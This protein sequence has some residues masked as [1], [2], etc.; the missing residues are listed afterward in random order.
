MIRKQ[1]VILIEDE[2][3]ARDE[4]K[5]ILR[6]KHGDIDAETPGEGW[7]LIRQGGVDGVFLDINL[8]TGSRREGMDL[9]CEI[10]NLDEPPW[11]VFT[12]AYREYGAEAFAVDPADFLLKPLDDAKVARALARV[13]PPPPGLVE[14]ASLPRTIEIKHRLA[15]AYGE[16]FWAV[17]YV[18]PQAE[19]LY[20]C[21]S[22]DSDDT[23]RVHLLG[24]EDLHGVAGPLK[25][26]QARLAPYGFV[27]IRR[28]H[29]VNRAFRGRLQRDPIHDDAQQL[30]LKGGCP[31][32]LPVRRY[33]QWEGAGWQAGACMAQARAFRR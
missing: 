4:L 22:P 24:C 16:K 33:F 26:W 13:P 21:T 23:L 20:V 27:S 1:R 11:I 3:L 2:F 30:L 14:P 5:D 31:D 15:D 7:R 19:I 25:D 28:D 12:T 8:E 9:A 18:D 6:R 10:N 32:R 17:E 29:L